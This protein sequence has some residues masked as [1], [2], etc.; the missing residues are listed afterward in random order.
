MVYDKK[1]TLRLVL[2]IAWMI[3]IFIM[4]NQPA[5]VSSQQSDL[6]VRLLAIVGIDMD[7]YF[8]DLATFII[9]K[10]AHMTE[11]FILFILW[12]RVLVLYVDNKKAKLYAL[13]LVF[14]YA[15]SDEFHQTFVPG[16]SG[17]FKDVMI[18][19]CGGVISL[20]VTIIY[21]NIKL[22]IKF[23]RECLVQ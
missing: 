5:E 11:Y 7:S 19:T 6:V 13:G 23:R 8:G 1:K 4:S 18:D 9:R 2:V 10:S 3:F 14:L 21:E 20:I 12:Y 22:R 15:S 16:R 17:E